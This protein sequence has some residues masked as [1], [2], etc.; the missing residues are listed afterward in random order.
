MREI[1]IGIQHP[2]DILVKM[3]WANR[4]NWA[5][6]WYSIWISISWFFVVQCGAEIRCAFIPFRGIDSDSCS[7]FPADVE[8]ELGFR[9][10]SGSLPRQLPLHCCHH[11]FLSWNVNCSRRRI[12]E[13]YSESISSNSFN[14]MWSRWMKKKKKKK[15]FSNSHWAMSSAWL[16]RSELLLF[17]FIIFWFETEI[18]RKENERNQRRHRLE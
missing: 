5:A 6:I 11:R 15:T 4:K 8:Q 1:W 7:F 2:V 10:G 18:K 14:Q 12:N 16:T 3:C 17:L 9:R 13:I